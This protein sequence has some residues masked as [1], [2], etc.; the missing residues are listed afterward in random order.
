MY[1]MWH[2]CLVLAVLAVLAV[3]PAFSAPEPAVPLADMPGLFR[4]FL[5][6]HPMSISQAQA[7]DATNLASIRRKLA[8]R[9]GPVSVSTTPRSA[10]GPARRVGR[11]LGKG[12]RQRKAAVLLEVAKNKQNKQAQGEDPSR[13]EL[14]A[15]VLMGPSCIWTSN[16]LQNYVETPS[17]S[18]WND[19]PCL[20]TTESLADIYPG[21]GR[22]A[23]AAERLWYKAMDA[24]FEQDPTSCG[25]GCEVLE[26]EY[27]A[28]MGLGWP[29]CVTS[30]DADDHFL[31]LQV[32][33][34][35]DQCLSG[36]L[37]VEMG[38][39]GECAFKEMAECTG[40]CEWYVD[41]G[42]CIVSGA[43]E[44]SELFALLPSE[45]SDV[46][47]TIRMMELE[48]RVNDANDASKC[49]GACTKKQD[50]LHP[51][52]A[53][54]VICTLD[55]QQVLSH[56]FTKCGPLGNRLQQA[57]GMD[58]SCR[59]F[60]AQSACESS[61][62]CTWVFSSIEATTGSCVPSERS[63]MQLLWGEVEGG[64]LFDTFVEINNACH[65]WTSL[66][67]CMETPNCAWSSADEFLIN[68][69]GRFRPPVGP[70]TFSACNVDG[71]LAN[72]MFLGTDAFNKLLDCRAGSE[73][74]YCVPPAQVNPNGTVLPAHRGYLSPSYLYSTALPAL[75]GECALTKAEVERDIAI[76][77][78]S[79][80]ELAA[81]ISA[82]V[83][84]NIPTGQCLASGEL[85]VEPPMDPT[86]GVPTSNYCY[87][88]L[89]GVDI[90]RIRHYT[91]QVGPYTTSQHNYYFRV[92][93]THAY[94]R[95]Q[96]PVM[97]P[98]LHPVQLNRGAHDGFKQ[99]GIDWTSDQVFD[100]VWCV[101]P[102]PGTP[103]QFH[104]CLSGRKFWCSLDGS[105]LVLETHKNLTK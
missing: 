26:D 10:K 36:P 29:I 59:G 104:L 23:W 63:G 35:E 61:A 27:L 48:C 98:G 39:A 4:R 3:V 38:A 82:T 89:E 7:R 31:D 88:P 21:E 66:G 71:A 20:P 70:I 94:C 17:H 24:C 58:L 16:Q 103:V 67:A 93:D 78:F 15:E 100:P 99:G 8:S 60:M 28:E 22:G 101:A 105:E 73:V 85:C 13:R 47:H 54:R 55:T 87:S 46:G 50:P 80:A 57:M 49:S 86:L 43:V 83:C 30:W 62:T 68:E 5:E 97:C 77:E 37:K 40:G 95:A 96:G 6:S 91:S 79:H 45:Y 51:N 64:D 9:G 72:A 69:F 32:S 19:Y 102:K 75:F 65:V 2:V 42:A 74:D 56:N 41:F 25:D 12:E 14:A 34:G 33:L 90:L 92:F 18:S 84:S 81:E 52:D 53:S 1:T 44:E 76:H 11:A